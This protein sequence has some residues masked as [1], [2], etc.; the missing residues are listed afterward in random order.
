MRRVLL[1]HEIM[2]RYDFRIIIKNSYCFLFLLNK[3]IQ[4][5]FILNSRCC[6]KKSCGNRNETPSD[7]V[8]QER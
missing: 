6:E 5:L 2:C 8:I 7:P 1:T 3:Q 4:Y